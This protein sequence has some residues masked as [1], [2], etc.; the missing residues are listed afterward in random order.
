MRCP[1]C[2]L[3]DLDVA[4]SPAVPATQTSPAEPA[5]YDVLRATCTCYDHLS[6]TRWYQEAIWARLGDELEAVRDAHFEARYQ[7]YVEEGW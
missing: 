4:L 3:G 2:N 7:R 1:C 5:E 6:D